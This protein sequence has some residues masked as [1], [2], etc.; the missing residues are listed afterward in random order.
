MLHADPPEH[1]R[2]RRGVQPAFPQHRAALR[3]QTENIAAALLHQMDTTRGAVIDLL[4]A[5][6][7]PLPIAVLLGLLDI[8]HADRA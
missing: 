3:P 1:T 8:P 2:L 7:R 6:A 5:Y 4:D